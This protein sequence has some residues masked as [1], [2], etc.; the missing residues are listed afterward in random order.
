MLL[1]YTM[2]AW[3]NGVVRYRAG[4]AEADGMPV[5]RDARQEA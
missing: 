1:S 3:V 2:V 5:G 4:V